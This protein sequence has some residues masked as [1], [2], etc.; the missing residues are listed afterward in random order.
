MNQKQGNIAVKE[1]HSGSF[2]MIKKV[3]A[4]EGIAGLYRGFGLQ[5][6]TCEWHAIVL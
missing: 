3:L 1:T 5:M 6:L 4:T 2:S